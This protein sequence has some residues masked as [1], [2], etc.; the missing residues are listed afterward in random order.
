MLALPPTPPRPSAPPGHSVGA[1]APAVNV[2]PARRRPLAAG[3]DR[4]PAEPQEHVTVRVGAPPHR[5]VRRARGC[6]GAYELVLGAWAL[7]GAEARV[8]LDAATR[9]PDAGA[10]RGA[11]PARTARPACRAPATR[12]PG[13][14]RACNTNATA[15]QPGARRAATAVRDHRG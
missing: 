2:A 13:S 3:V 10:R 5:N 12:P 1:P 9:R 14:A 11:A 15:A 8:R 6:H 7:P 4:A